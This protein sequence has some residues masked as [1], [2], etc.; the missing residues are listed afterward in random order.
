MYRT[1]AQEPLGMHVP[2]GRRFMVSGGLALQAKL[3]LAFLYDGAT[4]GHDI[5]VRDAPC[6]DAHEAELGERDWLPHVSSKSLK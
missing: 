6:D 1:S 4:F 5:N 2:E 3:P